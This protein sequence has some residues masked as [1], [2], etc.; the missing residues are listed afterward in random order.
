LDTRSAGGDEDPAEGVEGGV[1]GGRS[2]GRGFGQR[3]GTSSSRYEGFV[4][5]DERLVQDLIAAG[6]AVLGALDALATA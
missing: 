3:T 1:A 4:D 5:V 6:R 2:G